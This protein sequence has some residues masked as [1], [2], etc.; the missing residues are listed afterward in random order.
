MYGGEYSISPTSTQNIFFVLYI[1]YLTD[2]GYRN[3][4]MTE[5]EREKRKG[6][7]ANY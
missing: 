7:S 2:K 6:Q 4:S 5:R 1:I 3:K